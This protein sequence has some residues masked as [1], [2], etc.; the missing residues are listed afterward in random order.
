MNEILNEHNNEKARIWLF[1]ITH[2]KL[3]IRIYSSKSDEVIY[4]VMVGCEYIRGF[5]NLTNP[6]LS[7]SQYINDEN[8]DIMFKVIDNKTD[9]ELIATGG[10]TL[11]KGNESEFGNSLEKFL[12]NV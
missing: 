3:A 4:L 2:I 11:A 8:S 5:F 10:I 6:R 12:L 1:D 9:F 7:V